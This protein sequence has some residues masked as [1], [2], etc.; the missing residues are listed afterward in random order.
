MNMQIIENQFYKIAIL[1]TR[2]VY[3]A[4]RP[5]K[6]VFQIPLFNGII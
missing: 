1:F 3:E 6:N 4:K 2:N 5:L